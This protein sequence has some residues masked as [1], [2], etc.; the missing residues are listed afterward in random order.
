MFFF[1]VTFFKLLM[2]VL[3][4]AHDQTFWQGTPVYKVCV[5]MSALGGFIIKISTFSCAHKNFVFFLSYF[6]YLSSSNGSTEEGRSNNILGQ[7]MRHY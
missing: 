7:L 3:E 6:K 2:S 4:N 1:N 5:V